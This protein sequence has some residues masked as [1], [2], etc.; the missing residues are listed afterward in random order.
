MVLLQNVI[1]KAVT[2]NMYNVI[3]LSPGLVSLSRCLIVLHCDEG[4]CMVLVI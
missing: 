2:V 3:N 4:V 1:Q